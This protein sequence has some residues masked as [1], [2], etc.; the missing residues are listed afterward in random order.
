MSILFGKNYK[1]YRKSK[2]EH[3]RGVWIEGKPFEGTIKA[4]IQTLDPRE[5]QGL[6]IGREDTEK[7]KIYTD[8]VLIISEEGT[9]Q[10]GDIVLFRDKDYEVISYAPHQNDIINHNKY[11]AELRE[12][13]RSTTI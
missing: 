6:N 13:D 7:I 9:K 3:V 5:I 4:D 11:I 2:G 8:D 12:Y 1:I 10:N